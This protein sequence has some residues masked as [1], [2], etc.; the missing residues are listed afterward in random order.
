M[1]G[2]GSFSFQ[3][4]SLLFHLLKSKLPNNFDDVHIVVITIRWVGNLCKG[5]IND[6]ATVPY[7][8]SMDKVKPGKW[9]GSTKFRFVDLVGFRSEM[10]KPKWALIT[11]IRTFT[12]RIY[13]YFCLLQKLKNFRKKFKHIFF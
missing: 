13:L 2:F 11:L 1:D 9:F 5:Y 6:G 3:L 7:L 4:A 12:N 10:S 8:Q